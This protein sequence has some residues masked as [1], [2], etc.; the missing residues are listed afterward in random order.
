MSPLNYY[1]LQAILHQSSAA[2]PG[3]GT[4]KTEEVGAYHHPVSHEFT[5][6][7]RKLIFNQD[8]N[9]VDNSWE[10][11]LKPDFTV[12]DLENWV[13]EIHN[14]LRT[15][16][17]YFFEPIGN[18]SVHATGSLVFEQN[19]DFVLDMRF[20]GMHS[21]AQK[22]EPKK[23]E[24]PKILKPI[25][26]KKSKLPLI[27]GL[28]TAAVLI[29]VA[30]AAWWFLVKSSSN[31]NQQLAQAAETEA[32]LVEA[33]IVSDSTIS[34]VDSAILD[35]TTT[36]AQDIATTSEVGASSRPYFVIA[37]CFKSPELAGEYLKQLQQKGYSE[38]SIRGITSGG[39]TRVCFSSHETLE[40]ATQKAKELSEKEAKTFWIQ[41]I[42]N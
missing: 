7:T 5:P 29:L 9:L 18:L 8:F 25:A 34:S 42:E 19:P 23:V 20:F 41:K 3:L 32:P 15:D 36:P 24:T 27:L 30:F 35:T 38:A 26:A 21:F 40:L 16:K 4:F 28:S 1:L 22:P 2:I 37:G 11:I 31:Q 12:Q 10:S 17:K 39:L 13:K 6:A 33:A 14:Q